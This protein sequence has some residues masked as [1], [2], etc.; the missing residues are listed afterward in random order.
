MNKSSAISLAMDIHRILRE[1]PT[2]SDFD[3]R[4]DLR[5]SVWKLEDYAKGSALAQDLLPVIKGLAAKHPTTWT[6]TLDDTIRQLLSYAGGLR[7]G[8]M[9]HP[10]LWRMWFEVRKGAGV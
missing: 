4:Q 10:D 7:R 9:A 5:G 8:Q 6:A 3:A 1:L 2:S